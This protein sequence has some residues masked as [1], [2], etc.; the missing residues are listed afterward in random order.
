MTELPFEAFQRSKRKVA[1][2]NPRIKRG[3]VG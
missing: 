1:N 2:I 3:Q